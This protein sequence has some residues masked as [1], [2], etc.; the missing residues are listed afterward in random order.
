MP[1]KNRREQTDR[2]I[3]DA[4]KADNREDL[5]DTLCHIAEEIA[6]EVAEDLKGGGDGDRT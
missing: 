6:P 4:R 3:R 1:R 5:I 2:L